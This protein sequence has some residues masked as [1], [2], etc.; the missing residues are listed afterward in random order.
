MDF[1]Q[2]DSAT[3]AE[4]G[5]KMH[6]K[7][8]ATGDLLYDNPKGATIKNSKPCLVHVKGAEAKSV[9][10]SVRAAQKAR[11]KEGEK[12]AE[13]DDMQE[14]VNESAKRL[15]VGFENIHRGEKVATLKDVD[16]FLELNSL[17][18]SAGEKSFAEQ[19]NEFASSRANFLGNG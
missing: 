7:H 16:W 14:L 13:M 17:T 6:L 5:A 12:S 2:F 1:S 10:D 19:I 8:P 11:A 4:D 9:R 15:I 3:K 18:G